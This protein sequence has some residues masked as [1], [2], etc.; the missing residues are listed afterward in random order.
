LGMIE[1]AARQESGSTE[2]LGRSGGRESDVAR[3]IAAKLIMQWQIST[4]RAERTGE[5]GGG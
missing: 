2:V 1:G 3:L 5:N 4:A